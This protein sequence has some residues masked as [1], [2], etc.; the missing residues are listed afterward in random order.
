MNQTEEMIIKTAIRLFKKDGYRET[1]INDICEACKI[2]K[3]TFYYHFNAK[4]ELIFHYYE[5]LFEKIIT[6]MPELITMK[7]AKQKLWKLYEYSID[8]TVSLGPS[9]LQAMMI[10]DAENGLNYFSPLKSGDISSSRQLNS[11]MLRELIVQAQE[12]GSIQKA[13]DP[14]QLLQTYNAVIIGMALDWSSCHGSYD[15]KSKLKEM[16]EIV[17][18]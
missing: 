13:K 5:Y 12:E 9:L 4:S 16:F 14:E 15:Q 1:S 11:S 10:A 7:D 6:I 2:T 8:N 18:Q 3:G 17:F